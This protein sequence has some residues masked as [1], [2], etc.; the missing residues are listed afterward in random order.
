MFHPSRDA[1]RCLFP[2]SNNWEKKFQKGNHREGVG[3]HLNQTASWDV[4][5]DAT[6]T[7]CCDHSPRRTGEILSSIV[8]GSFS[9]FLSIR[10]LLAPD[11]PLQADGYQGRRWKEYTAVGFAMHLFSC[12]ST[13]CVVSIACVSNKLWRVLLAF[14]FQYLFSMHWF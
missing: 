11:E 8:N 3:M 2:D 6:E 10:F 13:F 1:H 5:M 4:R 7:Y 12:C 9:G 14:H